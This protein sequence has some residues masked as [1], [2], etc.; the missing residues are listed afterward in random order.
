MYE[1]FTDRAR[2]VLDLANEEAIRLNHEYI[3]TEH[4]LLG[5]AK[6]GAGVAAYVLKHFALELPR[7]QRE[8]ERLIQTGPRAVARSDLPQTPRARKVIEYAMD[9][10]RVLNHNYVGTEHLLLGLLREDEGVAAQILMNL[11]LKFE[12]VRHEVLSLLG[13]GI[14]EASTPAPRQSPYLRFTDRA[15]RV[16]QHAN[17]EAQRFSHEYIGTEHLLL[18]LL[19]DPSSVGMKAILSFDLD[20]DPNSIR[21]DIERLISVGPD[22][23]WLSN[24]PKTPRARK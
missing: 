20:L 17:Q 10:A 15:R 14:D 21:L 13:H 22:T 6:E 5:L 18:G 9:E 11:G 19:K 3:G 2:K 24:L 4:I 12:D 16:M 1:R 7:I 23:G 8:I